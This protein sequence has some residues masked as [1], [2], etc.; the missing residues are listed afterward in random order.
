MMIKVIGLGITHYI[1]DRVNI[2]D[3]IIVILTVAENITD[4]VVAADGYS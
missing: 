1:K 4:I 2:F 3:A